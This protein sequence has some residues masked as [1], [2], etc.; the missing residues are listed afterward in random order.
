VNADLVRAAEWFCARDAEQEQAAPTAESLAE[1][2]YTWYLNTTPLP[3]PTG[4]L[5][6]WELDL[7]AALRGAQRG[8]TRF[9][10]GW[11][12]ESVSSWGRAVAKRGELSRV[13]DRIE[14]SAPARRGLR[15]RPG[16]ALVVTHFW[17]WI[18]EDT[19]F[20][21]QRRGCWPPPDADRLVRTYWNVAPGDAPEV[22]VSLV[23]LLSEPDDVPFMLKTPA[24][25]DHNGRA[26]AIVLYLGSDGF[27]ACEPRL[28]CA[29]RQLAPSLRPATPRMTLALTPGVGLA[30]GRL[31]GESFGEMRC[32]L[33][34]DAFLAAPTESRAEPAALE[35]FVR[36]AFEAA[37]LDPDRPHLEPGADRDYDG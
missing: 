32:R 8:A 9:E 31:D 3:A 23:A 26:D 36:S 17:D 7:P 13:L 24:L 11:S 16:D 15:A 28:R 34:A 12:V 22:V 20:W 14:Y 4:P 30:E 2:L 19:S 35:P 33:L 21:H 1:A 27:A 5:L 29:A 37:G 10:G 6:P 18:D 25:P